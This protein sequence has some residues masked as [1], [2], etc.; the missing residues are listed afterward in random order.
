[1]LDP[2]QQAVI[3]AIRSRKHGKI[4]CMIG[5]AGTG[6]SYVIREIKQQVPNVVLACP[7]GQAA[8]IIGGQTIHSLFGIPFGVVINPDFI[9]HPIS[10][11]RWSCKSARYFGGKRAEV[12]NV[13]SWIVLDEVG[14]IRCDY[15]DFIDKALRI[16]RKEPCEPFGGA[17]ILLVG[18][19]GQLGSVVTEE[20]AAKLIKYGYEPPFGPFESMVLSA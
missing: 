2:D 5:S 4:L 8:S 19:E 3:D 18:D 20:D 14:M 9:S 11:Q 13:A 7:T 12:L 6:K 1:M 16:A 10:R 15:M 17:G